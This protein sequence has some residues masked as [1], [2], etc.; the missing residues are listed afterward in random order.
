MFGIKELYSLCKSD[1]W[2]DVAVFMAHFNKLYQHLSK[3]AQVLGSETS[4]KS[5]QSYDTMK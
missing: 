5:F 4:V 2:Q 3:G 1:E